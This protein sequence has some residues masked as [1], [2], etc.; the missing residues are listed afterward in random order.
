MSWPLK[1]WPLRTTI[2]RPHFYRYRWRDMT[3]SSAKIRQTGPPE[4][5]KAAGCH[6]MR[7]FAMEG[8]GEIT[9]PVAKSFELCLTWR[10][11][12]KEVPTSS[13]GRKDAKDY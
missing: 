11:L 6:S 13:R 4:K 10:C 5:A 7:H 8:L 1:R 12:A 2:P 9:V 3:V